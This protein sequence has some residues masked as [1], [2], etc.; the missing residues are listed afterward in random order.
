MLNSGTCPLEFARG[1]RVVQVGEDSR[2]HLA[3][4]P[5]QSRAN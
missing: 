1:H 4:P 3:Q 5:A 2:D